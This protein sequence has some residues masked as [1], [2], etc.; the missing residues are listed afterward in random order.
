MCDVAQG[1]SGKAHA[2]IPEMREP[3]DCFFL[4]KSNVLKKPCLQ[5]LP[6]CEGNFYFAAPT[7][8]DRENAIM[9]ILDRLLM[10]GVVLSA[11]A[12]VCWTS[13][14]ARQ[15]R[16]VRRTHSRTALM[17][18]VRASKAGRF[19]LKSIAGPPQD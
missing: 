9:K 19:A 13:H 2:R 10:A 11:L 7:C 4:P 15:R 18:R 17:F 14:C 1:L 8:A 6:G 3:S 16:L 5:G 12:S